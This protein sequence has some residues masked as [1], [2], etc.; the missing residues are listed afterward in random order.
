MKTLTTIIALL[1]LLF[2]H[3]TAEEPPIPGRLVADIDFTFS[4]GLVVDWDVKKKQR[5]KGGDVVAVEWGSGSYY[6]VVL[7]VWRN[8]IYTDYTPT[9]V[10]VDLPATVRKVPR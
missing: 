5:P 1:A 2:T 3:A 6:T 10:T 7:F 9:S 8:V 4:G